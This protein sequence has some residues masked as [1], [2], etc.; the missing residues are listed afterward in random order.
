[1]L[2][3]DF[4]VCAIQ[5]PYVDFRGASRT[6]PHWQAIY[7]TTHHSDTNVNAKYKKTRSIILVSAAISTDAWSEIPFDSLDVTGV[8]LVGDFGTIRII[9]IYNNCDD[10]SSLDTVAQ[11]LRSP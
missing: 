6:N 3:R 5:E 11:Y 1:S 7:P 9:N 4:E 8:Q 2:R 10:N